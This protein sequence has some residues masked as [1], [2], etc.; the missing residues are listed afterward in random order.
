MHWQGLFVQRCVSYQTS[1][2][3]YFNTFEMFLLA[4]LVVFLLS[5]PPSPFPHQISG[6]DC[7]DL[8]R[9]VGALVGLI[10]QLGDVGQDETGILILHQI[11]PASIPCVGL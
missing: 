9:S 10:I 3:V 1:P 2:V 11:W 8:L 5:H 4:N 7:L 6:K